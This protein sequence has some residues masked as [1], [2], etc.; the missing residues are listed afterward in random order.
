MDTSLNL[1]MNS[2][3]KIIERLYIPHIS[4]NFVNDHWMDPGLSTSLYFSS[5]NSGSL[6]LFKPNKQLEWSNY[7][8]KIE[9]LSCMIKLFLEG[10]NL[11][12][13]HVASSV[14]ADIR[15]KISVLIEEL[16]IMNQRL[17][18]NESE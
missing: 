8:R 16:S 11:G 15:K 10:G 14:N 5:L 4:G 9:S 13:F 6:S 12:N 1:E 3:K 7:Y 2:H 18:P 17:V